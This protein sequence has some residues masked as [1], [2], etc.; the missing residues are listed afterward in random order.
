MIIS[1]YILVLLAYVSTHV[2]V[3]SIQSLQTKAFQLQFT[4]KVCKQKN[5]S[6]AIYIQSLQTKK[7]FCCNLHSKSAN[8][9]AFLLQFTFKVCKQE[10]ISVA[11]Y[12]Q[13][14]LV[15][16]LTN[17]I[18]QLSISVQGSHSASDSNFIV[19]C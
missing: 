19:S 4:F 10:S 15:G 11:I 17:N 13:I 14:C 7:H 6:V 2:T 9:K 12:I 18:M 1:G 8:K 16:F 5:I 3:R